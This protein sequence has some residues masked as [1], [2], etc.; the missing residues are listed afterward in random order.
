MKFRSDA[1]LHL[2][3]DE[4]PENIPTQ[5]SSELGRSR[6]ELDKHTH[7]ALG[8]TEQQQDKPRGQL[9]SGSSSGKCHRESWCQWLP[10]PLCQATGAHSWPLRS[11]GCYSYLL[12]L[13]GASL[14]ANTQLR[15]Q[16]GLVPSA[17]ALPWLQSWR[18]QCSTA[19]T[20]ANPVASP[21]CR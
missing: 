3:R 15:V 13:T 21:G 2:Q 14:P 7:L 16:R 11:S 17:Q 8:N 12:K 5:Q 19:V 20:S 4:L 9:G 10:S 6:F 18:E 1:G